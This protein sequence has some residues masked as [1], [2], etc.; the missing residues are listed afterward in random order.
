MKARAKFKQEKKALK[1]TR[2]ILL[3]IYLCF[4]LPAFSMFLTWDVFVKTLVRHLGLVP[5]IINSV[6]II[7]TVKKRQFRVAFIELLLRKSLP[8]A[9]E[10][11]RRLFSSPKIVARQ[12]TG[13]ENAENSHKHHDEEPVSGAK[14]DDK[15]HTATNATQN[16]PFSSNERTNKNMSGGTKLLHMIKANKKIVP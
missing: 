8:E 13:Q 11:H 9:E 12:Q 2:I 5:V 10:Y 6:S 1:L 7:Y 3:T 4:S 15:Y 14:F 16:R